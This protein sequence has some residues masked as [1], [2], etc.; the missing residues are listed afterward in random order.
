M[1][2]SLWISLSAALF[3]AVVAII[4]VT[5][6][7]AGSNAPDQIVSA[8]AEPRSESDDL[9]SSLKPEDFGRDGLVPDTTRYVGSDGPRRFWVALD[10]AGEI[11]VIV[12]LGG[13]DQLTAAACNFAERV[14]KDGQLLGVQGRDGIGYTIYLIPDSALLERASSAWTRVGENGLIAPTDEAAKPEMLPKE[15]GSSIVLKRS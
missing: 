13:A 3:I 4:G 7:Q 11:C 8:L 6:A 2:T 14:A 9:P 1:R 5:A 15:D 10:S 12:A